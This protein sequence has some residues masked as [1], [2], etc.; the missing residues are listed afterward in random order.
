MIFNPGS[1]AG[2]GPA[3][4]GYVAAAIAAR[5]AGITVLAYIPTNY[6]NSP[7]TQGQVI[8]WIN[9]ALGFYACD[10]I[11]FDQVAADAAH[12]EYY[13]AV[14][15]TIRDTNR[16]AVLN[17][18]VAAILPVYTEIADIICNF[19]GTYADYLNATFPTW[20][21]ATTSPHKWWHII[22]GCPVDTDYSALYTRVSL[23]N[24]GNVFATDD[25]LGNPFDRI[26]TGWPW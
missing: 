6:G 1:N 16:I 5:A 17:P 15:D 9:N 12:V 7:N 20:V 11:F 2:V 19:E 13:R 22:H 8:T 26:P 23:N 18:G 3:D 10:G 24:A 25:V 21:A 4:A 14:C